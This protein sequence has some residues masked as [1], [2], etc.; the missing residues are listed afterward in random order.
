MRITL[1]LALVLFSFPYETLAQTLVNY[2]LLETVEKEDISAE[3]G[4]AAQTSLEHYKME[5]TTVDLNGELDTAS[6]L[7]SVPVSRD[8]I[9]PLLLHLHGTVDGPTDVPSNLAG[10]FQIAEILS[11][12]QFIGLSPDYLGLGSSRGLHPYVHADSEASAT[13]DMMLAFNEMADELN[14]HMNDQIFITGYSQGGHAAM[15]IHRELEQNHANDYTVTAASHMSGP[16]SISEKMVD[17]TLGEDEYFFVAYLASVALTMR[18]AY[19]ELGMQYAMS[20]LFKSNYL[21]PMERYANGEIGLFDLNAELIVLLGNDVGMVTPKDMLKEDILDALLNDPSHPLS[22][23]LADNDVYD[24]AP[25][26]PTRLLYCTAD[27]QV[28]FENALLAEEVMK[29]NGAASVVAINQGEDLNHGTCV[30]PS[31]ESTLLFFI[32]KR[33]VSV[34]SN[35]DELTQNSK[36]SIGQSQ[37]AVFVYSETDLDENYVILDILGN[38]INEGRLRGTSTKIQK[39]W[40]IP[41]IYILQL[42]KS[43]ASFK[44]YH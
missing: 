25:L 41:G 23:A 38:K 19:P 28:T 40:K 18:N 35:T 34:F 1:F 43:K 9:F 30:N 7:V 11:S 4:V 44:F 36:I 24:W 39:E 12:Y 5:Y 26:A 42:P 16:Y 15:A 37:E 31:V 17:Y 10:G 8:F 32:L 6:G 29:A 27:D 21:E 20:D 33:V 22:M 2:E 14:I 13:L 3:Y